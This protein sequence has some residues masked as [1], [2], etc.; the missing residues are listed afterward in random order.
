MLTDMKFGRTKVSTEVYGE[1]SIIQ[2]Q[3]S[4]N[5]QLFDILYILVSCLSSIHACN[6]AM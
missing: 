3:R 6:M 5:L 1:E 2:I 4:F